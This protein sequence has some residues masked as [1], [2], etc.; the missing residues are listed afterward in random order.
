MNAGIIEF[1]DNLT[2]QGSE[3]LPETIAPV[4][5]I[6][7]VDELVTQARDPSKLGF[8]ANLPVELAMKLD[9]PKNICKAF[10]LSL[11]EFKALV[12]NPVFVKAYDDA[13]E[14]LKI[15][16]M[17]F[18]L[19]ARMQAETLLGTSYGM[20]MNPVTSDAVRAD[21]I[22]STV[23]WAGYDAKAAEANAGPAFNIQINLG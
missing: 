8:P 1:D 11:D 13:V 6:D 2:Y 21:L 3:V 7:L 9:T 17:S 5:P 19:K 15:E 23:R 20:A 4:E 16:G 22:K 14:M 18:K 12:R 10:N